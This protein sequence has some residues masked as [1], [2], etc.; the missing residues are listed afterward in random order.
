MLDNF[1]SKDLSSSCSLP[2]VVLEEEDEHE[3]SKANTGVGEE[4]DGHELSIASTGEDGFR[5][6]SCSWVSFKNSHRVLSRQKRTGMISCLALE[7]KFF[8]NPHSTMCENVI[9]NLPM[10]DID[11]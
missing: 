10:F 3:L 1:A 9:R 4:E 11:W 8:C 6:S 5:L 2:T 7:L